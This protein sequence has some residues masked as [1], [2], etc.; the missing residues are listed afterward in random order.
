M[1][2]D[3]GLLRA[4]WEV[5][6]GRK[7]YIIGAGSILLA[8]GVDGLQNNDWGSAWMKIEAALLAMGIRHGIG[9]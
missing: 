5:L 1:L 2:E 7:T 6:K 4:I 8:I 3:I 9:S